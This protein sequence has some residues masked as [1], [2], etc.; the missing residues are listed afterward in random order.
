MSEK[1]FEQRIFPGLTFGG[2]IAKNKAFYFTSFEV[3][4]FD[5]GRFKS[6]TNNPAIFAITPSQMAYLSTLRNGPN[7]TENTRRIAANLENALTITTAT[8]DFLRNEEGS[9]T[10][11]ARTY[12]W[13]TRLDYQIDSRDNLTGR[14]TLAD[15]NSTIVSA[16]NIDSFGRGIVESVR[17]YTGVATWSRIFNQRVINQVRVQFVK[18]LLKQKSISEAPTISLAGIIISG[19]GAGQPNY[20]DQKR[21]QFENVLQWNRAGHN[22]KFGFSYRPI[23]VEIYNEILGGGSYSFAGG[24]PLTLLSRRRIAPR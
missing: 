16:Q 5:E 6:Y 9:R 24:L 13:T 15:E 17:D 23:D 18:D 14:F 7:A 22:L 10:L 4:K 20:I 1:N 8:L 2:P 11:P 19:R 12:N 21:Y 3:L